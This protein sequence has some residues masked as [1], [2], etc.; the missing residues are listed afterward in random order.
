MCIVL[1]LPMQ[2][3]EVSPTHKKEGCGFLQFRL[4]NMRAPIIMGFLRNGKSGFSHVVLFQMLFYAGFSKPSLAAVSGVVQFR[5]WN[6]PLQV[7]LSLTGD[8][9]EMM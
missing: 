5:N 7:H 8:P 4:V 2:Y 9:T 1:F 3:A 6:E